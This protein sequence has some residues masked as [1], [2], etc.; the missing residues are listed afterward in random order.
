MIVDF[1]NGYLD[2]PVVVGSVY[3]GVNV[4]KYALPD[5]STRSGILTP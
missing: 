5:H 2:N 3:N 1:L 4:P